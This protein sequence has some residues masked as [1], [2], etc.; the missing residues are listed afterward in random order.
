MTK[1]KEENKKKDDNFL[2]YLLI[3]VFLLA[4][5]Y[6]IYS[7]LIEK[8]E[9]RITPVPKKENVKEIPE[10]QFVKHG[11]LTF[12]KKGS[13]KP[14][15]KIDIEVAD[16]PETRAK[17]MMFRKSNDESRGMLFIF[18][19]EEEQSFWMQN[20]F[21]SLDIMYVNSKKEIVKIHKNATPRSTASIPSERKAIYVVEVNGGFSDKFEIKEGDK[22]DFNFKK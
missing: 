9:D 22:I 12:L 19:V 3:A 15:V 8:K 16:T 1:I 13:Q 10:P 11:E 7:L 20:T 17:G 21:I 14:L 6:L 2:R 18:P 4:A 5:L